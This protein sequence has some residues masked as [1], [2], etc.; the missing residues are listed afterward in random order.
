MANQILDL[1]HV[2]IRDFDVS[3]LAPI[4]HGGGVFG[5]GDTCFGR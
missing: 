2:A 4:G 5:C 1:M 3:F